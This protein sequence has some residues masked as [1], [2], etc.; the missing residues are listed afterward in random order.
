MKKIFLQQIILFIFLIEFSFASSTTKEIANELVKEDSFYLKQHSTNPIFWQP[1]HENLFNKAKKQNK[2]IFLSIGYSTCHWCHEMN[3][4]SFSDIE[5]ARILNKHYISI[6]VDKE[7]LPQIDFKYQEKYREFKN[8]NGGWPL[9]VILNHKKQ[10]VFLGTYLPKNSLNETV[11]LIETLQK[12]AKQNEKNSLKIL[13]KSNQNIKKTISNHEEAFVKT[14]LERYDE[15]FHGFDKQNKFPLTS[16]L[17]FLFDLHL[18]NKDETLKTIVLNTSKTLINNALQDHIQGGFYRYSVNQNFTFPHFEKML[19]TQAELLAL[20]YRLYLNTK[21]ETYLKA[22][23][24]TIAFTNKY[25]QNKQSLFYSA[26][27]AKEKYYLYDYEKLYSFLEENEFENIEEELEKIA[28]DEFGNLSNNLNLVKKEI[29]N[30]DLKALLKEFR[31]KENFPFID[32]KIITSWNAMMISSLFKI[33]TLDKNYLKQAINSLDSLLKN[34]YV[35]NTLYHQKVENKT[36]LQEAL[37]EDYV[38]LSEALINAFLKTYENKYLDLAKKL[39]FFVNENFYKDK[40]WFY[41]KEKNYKAYFS[42]RHYS[43]PISI[44]LNNLYSIANLNYDLKLLESTKI[45]IQEQKQKILNDISRFPNALRLFT[46]IKHQD[47]IL[48]TNKNNLL[49]NKKL[50]ETIKY[51]YLLTQVENT[52]NYLACDEKTCFYY[53]IDLNKVIE[54]I[55]KL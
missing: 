31:E 10:I 53:D 45:K 19:Y 46:R 39:S 15:K 50:I 32:K 38:F 43:S 40:T 51:P 25:L 11:G 24:N 33:S 23:K 12:Y 6:K 13:K 44:H 9:T 49:K 14:M 21:D 48:K 28:F 36:P 26:V 27:D 29:L 4:E 18:L 55:D 8:K 17:N 7:E 20:F 41:D 52:K 2:L 1:F 16:H 34:L 35:K 47:V 22:I 54:S 3:R 5:V 42:D 37:L 30:K